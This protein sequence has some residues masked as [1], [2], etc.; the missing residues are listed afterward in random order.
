MRP[1]A[2]NR[3]EKP[4][5]PNRRE[6]LHRIGAVAAGVGL[7]ALAVPPA[8]AG[9]RLRGKPTMPGRGT[10]KD[11]KA[12]CADTCGKEIDAQIKLLGSK[13]FKIRRQATA[14]LVAIGKAK[15]EDK[16]VAA[17]KRALVLAKLEKLRAAKD[18]EIAQRA[19]A[20]ILAVNPPKKK[21]VAPRQRVELIGDIMVEP[22]LEAAP[23]P[24]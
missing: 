6:F 7:G 5:Y 18:P 16:K 9:E 4:G 13:D 1:S 2:K 23:E 8:A 20:I 11:K 21:I 3:D 19:K 12:F 10:V 14:K 24:E 22:V 15:D 17:Q